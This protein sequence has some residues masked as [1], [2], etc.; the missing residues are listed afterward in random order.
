MRSINPATEQTIREYPDHGAT[1][2]EERLQQAERAFHDWRKTSF[3]QRAQL[4][5]KAAQV[6]RK[7]KDEFARLMT[8]EMGK[9]ITASEGEVEKCAVCC[10]YFADD[11]E[12]MLSPEMKESDAGKSFVRYDPLGPVLAIMPWN[13]PFWQV[14]RFAAPGLMAGN[15]GVLKHSSNVPG[16]ALAI[17]DVFRDAG[18]PPG[19]F[20]TLMIG[21][22]EIPDVIKHPVIRAVTLTGSEKAGMSGSSSKTKSPIGSRKRWL[23]RWPR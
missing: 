4:M 7:R 12:R 2:I 8:E 5:H 3:S 21:T 9:P 11:A 22:K 13:F 23:R 10:D 14:F 19:A 20:T 16:C 1:D 18:F 15:V 17:E 6:L